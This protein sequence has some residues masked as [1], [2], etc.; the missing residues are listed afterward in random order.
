[1]ETMQNQ[2]MQEDVVMFVINYKFFPHVFNFMK[3]KGAFDDMR[4]G[5]DRF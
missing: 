3:T 2:L 4:I 1:M 5:L